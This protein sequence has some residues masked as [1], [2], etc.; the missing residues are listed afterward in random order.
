MEARIL[1]FRNLPSPFYRPRIV[2]HAAR[3]MWDV[4][5]IWFTENYWKVSVADP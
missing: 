5:V 4:P 2:S 3:H 1:A